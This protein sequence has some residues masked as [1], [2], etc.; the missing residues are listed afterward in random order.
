MKHGKEIVTRAAE[1]A[2]NLFADL[3]APGPEEALATLLDAES[4]RIERIVS[5]G[6]ASPAGFWYDQPDGEWVV[7][8]Q[9][10]AELEFADGSGRRR[11][12]PGDWLDLPPHTRH[13]V[14]WT[15]PDGPTVWH[16]VHYR[17]APAA[18]M[19]DQLT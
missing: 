7:L 19:G 18:E 17:R 14:A 16:A 15:A 8:L 12:A 1:P 5:H 4:V 13:R 11:L 6:H 2:A 3:P 10:A 9:G